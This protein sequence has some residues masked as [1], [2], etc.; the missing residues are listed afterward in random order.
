MST[1]RVFEALKMHLKARSM[2]YADIARTLRVSEA[3][4]KRI[5]SQKNC[6]LARLDQICDVLQ[7]DIAD[8]ART[9]PHASRLINRL[10]RAQEHE[11]VADPK[12]FLVAVS[13]M[14]HMRIEDMVETYKIS[15][16][17]CLSLLL[18]LEKIGFLEVHEN[19]R[20]KLS[21]SRAFAWIPDGPIMRYVRTQMTEYFRHSFD[22]PGELMRIV[23]VR[24][25]D[26]A[27]VA[28]LSRMEQI[29]RE[30]SDQH[31]ADSHLPLE[32]RRSISVLLAVR[33]WEPA[34]FKALRRPAE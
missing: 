23:N 28:L 33:P 27:R 7:I 30:Y 32:Q 17:G 5:F 18:R 6:T 31:D 3:T 4:I 2:T 16:A 22:A 1:T 21:V 12:L 8:L 13:A 34:M 26:E 9:V 15:E 29:A 19:N 11:L 24:V 20:V 25:S 14:N 10:S